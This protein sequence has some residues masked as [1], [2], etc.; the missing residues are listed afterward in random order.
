MIK[1]FL[2]ILFLV[3]ASHA[4]EMGLKGGSCTLAQEGPVVVDFTAYK[5]AAKIGVGGVF[6]NVVYTPKAPSGKNFREIFVG[7]T[8]SIDTVSV[9]SKNKERDD[10]LVTFF[11]EK[12][13]DKN[14]SAKILDYKPNKRFK[15]KPK[16]G[17]FIVEIT[18]NGVTKTVSMNYVFD[19]GVM[20]A[21]GVIDILDF[22]ANNALS[23]INKA[24]YDLHEGKTWSDV[25][26]G[27]TTNVKYT[28]CEVPNK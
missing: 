6:D 17:E 2:S 11:F 12:M 9:N 21:N 8:L 14:I 27:F 1:I 24:C 3:V 4:S 13:V 22:S 7:A 28:L 16:T 5:T 19:E 15:G 23:S 25:A 20:K 26:I 10:K 18:M